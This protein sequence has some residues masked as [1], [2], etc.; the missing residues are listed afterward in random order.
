MFKTILSAA[1]I[2]ISLSTSAWAYPSQ[3]DLLY[4]LTFDANVEIRTQAAKSL[5]ELVGNSKINKRLMDLAEDT[6]EAESVRKEAIKSLG[7]NLHRPDVART[8]EAIAQ[9]DKNAEALR[10]LAIKALYFATGADTNYR[11]KML[12]TLK[13]TKVPAS[14]RAAAAWGIFKAMGNSQT[15]EDVLDIAQNKKEAKE[16]RIEAIKSLYQTVNPT[17]NSTRIR[18][19][20]MNILKNGGDDQSVRAAVTLVLQGV[21]G[22]AD[23]R[24]LLFEAA[25]DKRSP[26]VQKAAVEA[27]R[28]SLSEERMKD[29]HLD[30]YP[31]AARDAL[32]WE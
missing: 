6:N 14:L 19:G 12:N 11:S 28:M 26:L 9:D 25:R 30:Q 17:R 20:L 22:D 27:L 8:L 24:R 18:E 3:M 1:V 29:F 10:V 13:N 4:D 7:T 16:L 5:R 31:N 15:A 21:N 23:V 32:E 2:S